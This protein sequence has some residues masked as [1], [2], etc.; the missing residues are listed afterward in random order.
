MLELRE[1]KLP[2]D[3]LADEKTE[4]KKLAAKR[5]G[6]A[7]SE[8]REFSIRRK[9]LDARKKNEICYVYTLHVGVSGKE[10]RF[11]H[12]KGV[13]EAE[14][15]TYEIK[16]AENTGE[17]PVIVGFGPAGMFAALL[18]AKAGLKPIIL[19]RG[20]KAED[21]AKKVE[22]FFREGKLDPE[23]NVQFGE[24]GTGT[25]SDGKLNTGTHN[26]R[27]GWVL[28]QFAA[29]GAPENICY[30]AKPHIGTDILIKVV[31]NL[32]REIEK[33]GGEVRFGAKFTGYEAK[34][35]KL[36]GVTYEKD[37]KTEHLSCSELVLAIGHS[38]RDTF[39][40]LYES[41]LKMEPKA[42]SMGVR[43]EHKQEKIGFAQ[44]GEAYKKLPAAD[45]KLSCR[46]EKGTSAYTFCMCPG[47]AVVAAASEE[48]GV[49]TNG[50]SYSGRDLENANSALLV[51]LT[52]EDFPYP[53]VMG[54]VIWQRE[55]EQKA[56]QLSNGYFAPA[57]LLGDF[58]EKKPSSGYRSVRPSYRPGVYFTELEKVLPEK[59]TE[60]LR[61]AIP[62]FA[63][64]LKGFDDP[65]A[66][67]TAPETRS[68]SPV[69]ILRGET[70]ET[71]IAGIYPAGEGAGYAGGIV[72]AAV[73]G[74]LT[75]EAIIE[76]KTEL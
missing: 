51:T 37:G 53:G 64:K 54:G 3:K 61:E 17:R 44:Y 34:D 31:G 71:D 73:D 36:V 25:F 20:E 23:S 58:L 27:I 14:I 75:A 13:A 8:I 41:G 2:I 70:R 32:R 42:F 33:L 15:F 21:R 38:A 68:S 76:R 28:E 5:L 52:P 4:L 19:E 67:L 59:T 26:K 18:L 45:Y 56:Y 10:M 65:D 9:A 50:M 49:V 72:S 60:T 6:I 62:L 43:I 55:I 35:G 69:R 30:D 1:I 24:G 66:V 63:R 22:Q 46:T 12:K 29:F 40:M 7:V 48:G 57:Q 47:G 16:K 39:S 74:L 11:Y